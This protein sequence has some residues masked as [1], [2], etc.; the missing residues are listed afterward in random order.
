M[1]DLKNIKELYRYYGYS[2]GSNELTMTAKVA[3]STFKVEGYTD[4]GFWITNH[5]G[6]RWVSATGKKRFAYPTAEEALVN[7]VARKKS[8]IKIMNSILSN[9]IR[10]LAEAERVTEHI[11]NTRT[12]K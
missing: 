3:L 7:F 9:V 6:K 12:L 1:D 8:Q 10:Q 11:Y 5:L 2:C 4:K